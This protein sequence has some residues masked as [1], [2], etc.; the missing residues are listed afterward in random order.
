[1]P[2]EI[3]MPKLSSTMEEGTFLQWFVEEG[4]EI[5]I[6]DPLFEIMTDKINIEVEAYEEGVLLKQ[7]AEPDDTIPVNGVVG[8]IG[9]P[10]EAIPTQGETHSNEGAN[11]T[12]EE[13]LH[14][15]DD[16][17]PAEKQDINN[18]DK[19]DVNEHGHVRATPA[20]RRVAREREL[21]LFLIEGS[22][23]N[24]RIQEAD[25][26][27]APSTGH[28]VTS[29]KKE[30]GEASFE[31]TSVKATPLA[32]KIANAS[33]LDLQ[34]VEGTGA[35]G[36][37]RKQD[38]EK[39]I[40]QT[41]EEVSA[42]TKSSTTKLSGI[43]KITADRMLESATTIPH[44]TLTIDV[45]MTEIV[46]LRKKLLPI[47]EEAT[48]ARLSYNELF[49][50]AVAKTL[51]KHLSLNATLENNTITTYENV[52]L[53]MAVSVEDQLLVPV[54]KDAASKTVTELVLEAKQIQQQA[55][56]NKLSP[57][58]LKGGTFTVSNLG[59]YGIR[60]FTPIINKPQ[61]AILGV[62]GLREELQLQ[63]GQPIAVPYT[64]LSLSFDHRAV[65]GAPAAAF[66]QSL[67]RTLEEPYTLFL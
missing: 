16:E 49:L 59:M 56:A 60:S 42:T 67:K 66:C 25:V 1:M 5:E 40:H 32:A 47:V 45:N 31:P 14:E 19:A 23:P 6:G 52:H 33:D 53:G 4:E 11:A 10:G 21:N 39:S 7:L 37:V 36:K 38:V 48:G 62:G 44:V 43:R 18:V 13:D 30:E 24:G 54:I 12:H 28:A 29:S 58:T 41:S 26:E 63:N 20:A 46:T 55:K 34:T 61:T 64:T 51:P 65:N 50:Y 8:Y 9:E 22:G 17:A 27:Q 2:K 3:F 57:D 15:E 35:N